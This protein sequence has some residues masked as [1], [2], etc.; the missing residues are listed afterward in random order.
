M[1]A[2]LTRGLPIKL[3][4]IDVNDPTGR[5]RA[6]VGRGVERLS[7]RPDGEAGRAGRAP[8]QRRPGYSRRLRH[9]GR[10]SVVRAAAESAIGPAAAGPRRQPW[11][12]KGDRT[13]LLARLADAPRVV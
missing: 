3:D 1:L 13:G 5:F 12:E 6:A 2:E 4:L 8:L 11:P 7:R 9:V 10:A